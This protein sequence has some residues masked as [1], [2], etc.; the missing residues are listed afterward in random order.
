MPWRLRIVFKISRLR[1]LSS[2]IS[3]RL[4]SS[5]PV[6]G[7]AWAS[8]VR[9]S[10]EAPDRCRR[11][12]KVVPDPLP[13]STAM[14]PSMASTMLLT[15]DRPM[16]LPEASAL[17]GFSW[18]KGSNTRFRLSGAMPAPV[19]EMVMTVSGDSPSGGSRWQPR[20]TVPPSGVNFMALVRRL[21]RIF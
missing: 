14:V 3:T 16:P 4:P 15:M 11:T 8:S 13:L 9:A 17:E 18:K 10:R 19:S 21:S 5:T 20:R 6:S 1:L 7:G 2:Q 12:V